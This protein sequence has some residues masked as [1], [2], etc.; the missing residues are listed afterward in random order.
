M[1]TSDPAVGTEAPSVSGAW[2]WLVIFTGVMTLIG[3]TAWDSLAA[4]PSWFH[5]LFGFQTLWAIFGVVNAHK[6]RAA[7]EARQP[8]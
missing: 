6:R 2:T 3:F 7:W 5:A 1:D 4:A 8:E